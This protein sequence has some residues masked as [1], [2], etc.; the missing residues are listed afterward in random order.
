[1]VQEVKVKR[2]KSA[3]LKSY[4]WYVLSAALLAGISFR[5]KRLRKRS[6]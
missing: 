1:M 4:N 3:W 2:L 6:Q 5:L